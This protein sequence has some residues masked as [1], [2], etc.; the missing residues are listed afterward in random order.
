MNP[1]LSGVVLECQSIYLNV[2]IPAITENEGF[3][4]VSSC[5]S[6]SEE[7]QE[8]SGLESNCT[9]KDI[10]LPPVTDRNTGIVYRN[11][12]CAYCNGVEEL[13]TWQID[14]VC[15]DNVH[16]AIL[17]YNLSTLVD[18]DPMILQREC[19]EWSY[20]LPSLPPGISPPRSCIA[21]INFCLPSQSWT[22][23]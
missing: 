16:K 13:V 1:L 4:M 6:C 11:E 5:P 14:L 23:Y 20:R 19:Q 12:Y 17:Q 3:L 22:I 10:L 15:R 8:V 9:N 18:N 2:S 21:S 7:V